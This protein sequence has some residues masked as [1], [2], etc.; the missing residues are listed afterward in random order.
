[1]KDLLTHYTSFES[2]CKIIKSQYFIAFYNREEIT[3]NL[4]EDSKESPKFLVPMVCFCDS[5]VNVS[6]H[7]ETYGDVGIGF[8]K[9][10]AIQKGL[11]TVMYIHRSSKVST[12]LRALFEETAVNY[13]KA[14]TAKKREQ[15]LRTHN[16]LFTITLFTKP[17]EGFFEK[18]QSE[19]CYYLEREW[20]YI[21]ELVEQVKYGESRIVI[22]SINGGV[23][24]DENYRLYFVWDQI[25]NIFI[26]NEYLEKVVLFLIKENLK[27]LIKKVHV[28][29]K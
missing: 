2:F 7:I 8:T 6:K 29:N 25:E 9:E 4:K 24:E 13:R 28:I 10:W 11:I 27:P 20:R 26:A 18:N 14:K 21:P 23:L 16:E 15:I 19:Q 1:M 12:K 17:Y 3:S 22:D 5:D